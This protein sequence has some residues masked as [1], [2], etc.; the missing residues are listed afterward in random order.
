MTPGMLQAR[1]RAYLELLEYGLVAIRNHAHA[2][3]MKLCEVEAD[4]LHNLPSLLYETN[5]FRHRY[6]ICEERSLYVER[7]EQLGERAYPDSM[8]VWYAGSWKVLET[9]AE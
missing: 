9:F 7:L 1:R 2:G 3:R 5:E 6:Y 8:R 4:H